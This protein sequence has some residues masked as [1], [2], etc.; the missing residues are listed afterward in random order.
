MVI[1]KL[2]V[3]KSNRHIEKNLFNMLTFLGQIAWAFKR[4]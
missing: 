2:V 3:E 4:E 1:K